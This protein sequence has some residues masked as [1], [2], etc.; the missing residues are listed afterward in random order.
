MPVSGS[1][2]R[3][4]WQGRSAQAFRKVRVH[5]LISRSL[6]VFLLSPAASEPITSY[7]QLK[8]ERA[9]QGELKF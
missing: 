2:E 7:A 1:R 8:P 4:S 9:Y 6:N 3:G 5:P